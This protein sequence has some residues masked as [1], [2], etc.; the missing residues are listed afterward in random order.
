MRK[1]GIVRVCVTMSVDELCRVEVC[2][3]E[4]VEGL[5][6]VIKLASRRRF[7]YLNTF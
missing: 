7:N 3:R 1:Y 6:I 5:E 2:V 4:G